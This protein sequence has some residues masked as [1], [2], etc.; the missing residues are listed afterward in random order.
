MQLGEA[1]TGY[2]GLHPV[3]PASSNVS[4]NTIGS[5][6][7]TSQSTPNNIILAALSNDIIEQSVTLS[8]PSDLQ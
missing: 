5:F 2:F 4:D 3:S 7:F 1:G 8:P 6:P